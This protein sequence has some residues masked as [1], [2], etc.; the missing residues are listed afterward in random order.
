MWKIQAAALPAI[1]LLAACHN[2]GQPGNAAL[3]DAAANGSK[4]ED[5]T[6]AGDGKNAPTPIGAMAGQQNGQ[7]AEPKC[8]EYR[9]DLD[10]GDIVRIY[11]AV[12]GLTPP[13]E[14]WAERAVPYDNGGVSQEEAWKRAKAKVQAQ[15]DA[16]KDVRCF[17]IRTSANIGSYDDARGGLPVG[18]IR[19]D[20]YFTF[21]EGGDYV[22]VRLV[23]ADKANLWKIPRDRAMALTA[24]YGLN[25]ATAVIR[26][27][28]LSARPSDHGGV[29]QGRVTGYD[30]VSDRNGVQPYSV[31]IS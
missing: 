10:D 27:K 28:V 20:R 24:N 15:W 19:P 13:L 18:A 31:S 23:N 1:L 21:S 14:K 22:Q 3:S 29:I 12:A 2:G 6:A 4:A 9:T 30:I 11:Y 16:V 5:D 7:L 25:G 17:T 8:S 26:I